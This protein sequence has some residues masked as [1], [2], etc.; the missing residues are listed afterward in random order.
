M[1]GLSV[2]ATLSNPQLISVPNWRQVRKPQGRIDSVTN[3]GY[4]LANQP[5]PL[6]RLFHSK[7]SAC[8]RRGAGVGLGLQIRRQ[9]GDGKRNLCVIKPRQKKN[10]R[11]PQWFDGPI[12]KETTASPDDFQKFPFS[13]ELTSG[14]TTHA[15]TLSVGFIQAVRTGLYNG[16][17]IEDAGIT[18][19]T[20][21]R[22]RWSDLQP[23][24]TTNTQYD[25]I[26]ER[27]ARTGQKNGQSKLH[28]ISEPF[29]IEKPIGKFSL[30][31][32]AAGIEK[33]TVF[34]AD[35][36][37]VIAKKKKW[38]STKKQRFSIPVSAAGSTLGN[39]RITI[40]GKT[41]GKQVLKTNRNVRTIPTNGNY[42]KIS[43]LGFIFEGISNSV[44]LYQSSATA[45]ADGWN[46]LKGPWM[47][48]N[49]IKYGKDVDSSIEA[50]FT[51]PVGTEINVGINVAL[52]TEPG[53]DFL[54]LSVK[55]SGGVED[56]LLR[57]KSRDGTKTFDGI[58]GRK[59][60]V[61]KIIPFTTKSKRFSVSLRFT[62]DEVV[63]FAGATIN[64]FT[65][66]AA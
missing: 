30:E 61:R 23:N 42:M 53:H 49:G 32:E 57:S 25:R 2:E 34:Q 38:A 48:G 65:V 58:S 24:P 33:F 21:F 14:S 1:S 7:P 4:A 15:N 64:S 60:S 12:Y 36:E 26:A 13:Q 47:I 55:S 44:G 16:Q 59:R 46:N 22:P 66:S 43:T 40:V 20:V 27:L 9:P 6:Q 54:Y 39:N 56:F 28:F 10:P 62:S 8:R 3:T 31:V 18:A 51:A 37:T 19:D 5:G 41:A 63:E 52:D 45:P 35:G 17:T 29:E 11:N 50:F